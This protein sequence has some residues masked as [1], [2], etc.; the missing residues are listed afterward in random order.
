MEIRTGL[1]AMTLLVVFG[2][3]AHADVPC[4]VGLPLEKAKALIEQA[5]YETSVRYDA[6]RLS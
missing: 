3:V 2:A 5:G 4:V 6:L 1:A